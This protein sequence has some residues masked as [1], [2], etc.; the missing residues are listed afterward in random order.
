MIIMVAL[1]AQ[2]GRQVDLPTWRNTMPRRDKIGGGI[3]KGGH[4]RVTSPSESEPGSDFYLGDR[5]IRIHNSYTLPPPP[6]YNAEVYWR[7]KG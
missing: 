6:F 7:L 4:S 1:M 5:F 3:I 2:L